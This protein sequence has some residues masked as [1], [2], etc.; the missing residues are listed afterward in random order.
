MSIWSLTQ[1]RL[2]L[3]QKIFPQ[4]MSLVSKK[5]GCAP[6]KYIF[7][8]VAFQVTSSMIDCKP[9][10]NSSTR[11]AQKHRDFQRRETK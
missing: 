2:S 9:N 1:V 7:G 11:R 8:A 6:M 10:A 5:S 3:T 4:L